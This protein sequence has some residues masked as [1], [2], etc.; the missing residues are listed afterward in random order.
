VSA[1][2]DV[3]PMKHEMFL[4]VTGLKILSPDSFLREYP[5]GTNIYVMNTNYINEIKEMSLSRHHYIEV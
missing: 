5:E 4:P 1:V 2:V 3:N